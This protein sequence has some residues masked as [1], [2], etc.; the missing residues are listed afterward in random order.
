M[1]QTQ[2]S[3]LKQF[4]LYVIVGGL[5]TIV[6]WVFFYAFNTWW[7]VDWFWSTAIAFFFSTL[8]NWGF[9][10][11]LV[12]KHVEGIWK[13]LIKVYLTSITG[14]IFNLVLM[15]LQVDIL[16]MNAMLSKMIATVIVFAWNYLI[17]R[18]FIYKE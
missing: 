16:G 8:A 15:W 13:D 6:E 18:Y 7:Y 3:N 9:G 10:R 12:F 17:R 4:L 2:N 14:L 5:A 11:L 1:S